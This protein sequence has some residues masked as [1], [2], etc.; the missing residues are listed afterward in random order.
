MAIGKI[1]NN[2]IVLANSGAYLGTVLIKQGNY[3]SALTKYQNALRIA[4]T[5]DEKEI[6]SMLCLNLGNLYVKTGKYAEAWNYY[7]RSLTIA[8][9]I[10][11]KKKIMK[12]YLALTGYDSASGN[13]NEVLGHYKQYILYRDSMFNEHNARKI[14][15]AK[16]TYEF[17]K[18]QAVA[19]EESER[20]IQEQKLV[21]NVFIGGFGL[22]FIFSFVFFFQR[23]K[24]SKEKKRSDNLLL[25][26]LP[27]ETAEELKSKGSAVARDYEQV[28]VMFTDFKNFTNASEMLNAQELVNEINY[29]YSEFDRIVTRFGI[30]K[31]KTIGDGYMAAG[32]L[33]V[34]N[35]TNAKDAINAALAIRDFIEEEKH[36]R[37]KEG[38]PFFEIRIGLHTGPVVAGIVGIKKFAY[39]IWG[40]TV[41]IASRMESSGES[42]KVNISGATYNLVKEQFNCTYRG[43]IQAKN[44]G[45]IDMYFVNNEE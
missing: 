38:K 1:I 32:G 42:G 39:D 16:L 2:K 17:E 12:V 11:D 8:K 23:K 27:A 34:K 36:K 21:K 25:N 37:Q 13:S 10:K 35:T 22:A 15:N 20:K 6:V 3:D 4:D 5:I 24:I 26:I 9:A 33:P 40:D 44:K 7:N 28:T 29:C 45:E 19:N 14:E 41:N 30:E 43:K 31:I 18:Q